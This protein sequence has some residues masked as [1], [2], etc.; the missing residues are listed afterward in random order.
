M[1]KIALRQLL[2]K[3]RRVH[4]KMA[5]LPFY[6]LCLLAIQADYLDTMMDFVK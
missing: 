2:G 3:I 1:N 5:R 6:A 4:R